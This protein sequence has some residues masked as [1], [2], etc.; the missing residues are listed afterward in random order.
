MLNRLM[1]RFCV[2]YLTRDAIRYDYNPR[3]HFWAR[4]ELFDAG[5]LP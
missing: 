1:I 3:D 5:I 2:W 4:K